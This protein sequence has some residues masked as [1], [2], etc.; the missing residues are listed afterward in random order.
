M[1]VANPHSFLMEETT[2]NYFASLGCNTSSQLVLVLP[3]T[4]Q[5]FVRNHAETENLFTVSSTAVYAGKPLGFQH[6]SSPPGAAASW[7]G[8]MY[9]DTAQTD[10]VFSNGSAWYK[11]SAT[12]I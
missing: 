2:S 5:W 12:A 9:W 6:L 4:N 3:S 10:L 7:T 8:Y 11:I 1:V